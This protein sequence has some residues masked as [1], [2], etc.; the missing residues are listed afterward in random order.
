K[1]KFN[2]LPSEGIETNSKKGEIILISD[3]LQR[4]VR[5]V[6]V[7]RHLRFSTCKDPV[8]CLSNRN[9]YIPD[10]YCRIHCVYRP[11]CPGYQ[12]TQVWLVDFRSRHPILPGV[13]QMM[14]LDKRQSHEWQFRFY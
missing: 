7:H 12:K 6:W 9:Q 14:D 2:I 11:V 13:H 4:F 1:H 8:E 10:W 5:N 3:F